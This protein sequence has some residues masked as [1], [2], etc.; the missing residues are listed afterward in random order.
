MRLFER[1]GSNER[2]HLTFKFRSCA[3]GR[4]ALFVSLHSQYQSAANKRPYE[5]QQPPN[6]HYSGAHIPHQENKKDPKKKEK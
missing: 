4:R 6:T 5:Q 1:P 2:V 3:G